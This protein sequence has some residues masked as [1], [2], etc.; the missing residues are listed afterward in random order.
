MLVL[1][2]GSAVGAQCRKHCRC[3][4]FPEASCN[5]VTVTPHQPDHTA[6]DEEVGEGV[7]ELL[8]RNVFALPHAPLSKP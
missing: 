2:W 4:I 3:A 8:Y 6:A 7:Y 1:C 5:N